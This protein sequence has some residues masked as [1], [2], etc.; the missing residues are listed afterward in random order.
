MQAD[1]DGAVRSARL[2]ANFS[3]SWNPDDVSRFCDVAEWRVAEP[4]IRPR[5]L[6]NLEIAEPIGHVSIGRNIWSDEAPSQVLRQISFRLSSSGSGSVSA[7]ERID[8]FFL[9]GS[10][11]TSEFGNPTQAIPG[12]EPTLAWELPELSIE[13][14]LRASYLML[15]IINPNYQDWKNSSRDELEYER[16]L[17]HGDEKPNDSVSPSSTLG[18]QSFL[19]A[20]S[21]TLSRLPEDGV[22]TI[23]ADSKKWVRFSFG[24]SSRLGLLLRCEFPQIG[25]IDAEQLV[26][27]G[28]VKPDKRSR[29]WVYAVEWPTIY[30]KYYA[31]SKS[32][33]GVLRSI[34]GVED[35]ASISIDSQSLS[36]GDHADLVA[37]REG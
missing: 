28:W 7:S 14:R 29:H 19:S 8:A 6:T 23:V 26:R 34:F 15:G 35:A 36:Y 9:A 31:L 4:S 18:W 2:A 24:E 21:L 27:D 13:L 12:R 17:N 30:D 10:R 22:L 16:R 5:L 33:V 37:F 25:D 3:W 20:L 32:A 11:L 1:I